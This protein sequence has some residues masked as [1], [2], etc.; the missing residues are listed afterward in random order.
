MEHQYSSIQA[1]FTSEAADLFKAKSK[2]LIQRKYLYK[3]DMSMGF[4]D[5]P[6][7]TILFGLHDATPPLCGMDII[8]TH[9]KFNITLGTISIFKGNESDNPFDVIKADV[10]ASDVYALNTALADACDHTSD[11]PEYIPH[12]TMAFV[13]KDACNHLDGA[14]LMSGISF[15]VSHLIYSS[16][17]G[18]HRLLFLG[19]K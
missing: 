18:S 15:V 1:N 8:E 4:E 16:S 2:E 17:D 9:P 13:Q 12:A 14:N 11:F 10:N 3:P 6:H 19:Q 7:V 5:N